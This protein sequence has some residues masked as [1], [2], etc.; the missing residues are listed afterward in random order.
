MASTAY[1]SSARVAHV[2]AVAGRRRPRAPSTG[3]GG[4]SRGRGAARR[5][6]A[7]GGAARP[8]SWRWPSSAGGRRQHRREAPVLALGEEVVGRR[9]RRPHPRRTRSGRASVVAVAARRRRAGR[10][11]G[12]GR[13]TRRS[14]ASRVELAAHGV[15]G[16]GVEGDDVGVDVAGRRASR[17]RWR[18][19][20]TRASPV[21]VWRGV[22]AE[23]GVLAR[24]RDARHAPGRVRRP[25]AGRPAVVR[26]RRASSS[27]PCDVPVLVA[28]VEQAR[29]LALAAWPI[30][31]RPSRLRG[32]RRGATSSG[33]AARSTNS[34]FQKQ[35]AHRRVGAGIERLVEPR[36]EQ[37][38]RA[39]DL[40]AR[41]RR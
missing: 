2:D 1:S 32:R 27:T 23:A 26:P 14:P 30:V 21:P 16:V 3:G 28:V 17:C 11:R 29:L 6:P 10:G 36:R 5:R 35:P 38:Q 15:L 22:G 4:P 41:P 18:R 34:S 40:A 31:R 7:G 12:A 13:A 24:R 39:D 19:R 25:Q 37:R 8:R 33:I 20:A 9:A